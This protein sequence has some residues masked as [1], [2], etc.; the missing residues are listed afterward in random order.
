MPPEQI[1]QAYA[2]AVYARD[3]EALLAL[4]HPQVT[5]YDMWAHWLYDGQPQWRGMVE[6]WFASLGDER[7]QVTFD[8]IRSHA[9]PEMAL[10]HAF[11]T[12]AGLSA[13]GERLRAM[14]NRL[15]LTLTRSGDRWLILH[16][17]SSAP[18]DFE[19]GK[20]NLHRPV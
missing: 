15:S 16:E 11:V 8:D 17:H 18:A 5:V 9:T 20:V 6:G 12:Y 2:D 13:S 7:V 3:A 10:V 1:L 14:N 19:T 4:Y